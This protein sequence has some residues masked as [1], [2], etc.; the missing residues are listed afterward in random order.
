MVFYGFVC[1]DVLIN[2]HDSM[3]QSGIAKAIR[4]I[5]TA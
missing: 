1:I 5:A 3:V 2:L 4:I